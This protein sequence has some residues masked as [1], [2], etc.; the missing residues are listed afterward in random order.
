MPGAEKQNSVHSVLA[1][2]SQEK[3]W[4]QI[5]T[6]PN[7]SSKNAK[8]VVPSTPPVAEIVQV[9]E[10][11]AAP[12]TDAPAKISISTEDKAVDLVQHEQPT[13]YNETHELQN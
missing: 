11:A 6:S 9:E 2:D 1:R 8:N 3:N 4:V 12:P 10:L 13:S 5:S 7:L